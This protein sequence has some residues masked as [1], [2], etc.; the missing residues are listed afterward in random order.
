MREGGPHLRRALEP[1]RGIF[2]KSAGD[3]RFDRLG[4]WFHERCARDAPDAIDVGGG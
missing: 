4:K 1:V 3:D 2:L